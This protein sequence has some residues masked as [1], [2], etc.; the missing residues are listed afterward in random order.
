MVIEQHFYLL[1]NRIEDSLFIILK[2][3][4]IPLLSKTNLT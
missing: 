4:L 3:I 2:L 1:L